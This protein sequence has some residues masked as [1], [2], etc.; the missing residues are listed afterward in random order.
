MNEVEGKKGTES[1][2]GKVSK[3]TSQTVTQTDRQEDVNKSG[4][5]TKPSLAQQQEMHATIMAKERK[6]EMLQE[7]IANLEEQLADVDAAS[8]QETGT[9]EAT[10]AEE[11]DTDENG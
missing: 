3:E 6:R 10:T 7:H 1:K 2:K 5:A 4:S 9:A 8:K 11:V